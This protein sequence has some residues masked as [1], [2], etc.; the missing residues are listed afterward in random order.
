[1][2]SK[3]SQLALQEAQKMADEYN[4]SYITLEYLL[5]ALCSNKDTAEALMFCNVDIKKLQARLVEFIADNR[6]T[7][8]DKD[9]KAQPT[10]ALQRVLERAE[11]INNAIVPSN[12]TNP[13]KGN[14]IL[15]AILDEVD[16][17]AVYLLNSQG[18][19]VEDANDYL[20]YIYSKSVSHNSYY[21]PITKNKHMEANATLEHFAI[22]TEKSLEIFAVNLNEKVIAENL[23]PLVGRT[24]E[25]DRILQVLARQRKNNPL[26][27]GD[28]GVGKSAIVL[29]LAR[30]IEEGDA[31]KSMVECE[32]YSLDLGSLIAGTRYRGDLEKR[33]RTVIN[34]LK[35]KKNTILFID[36]IHTLIGAGAAG[37]D[38]VD[39]YR[40][41][42]PAIANGSVRCIGSTNYENYRS[43]FGKD[44]ALARYFQTVEVGKLSFDE[45]YRILDG[46]RTRLEDFHKVFYS[47]EAMK[48]AI[49]LSDRHIGDRHQPDKAIDIMDE[50][51]AFQSII[52]QNKFMNA[53]K[54]TVK[55]NHKDNNSYS[56]QEE[57]H[58]S[59]QV[60]PLINKEEIR[61]AIANMTGL[62]L[63]SLSEDA[64]LYLKNLEED[65]RQNIFG[66][67]QA[68]KHLV[69]AI[70][71]ARAGLNQPGRPLGCYMLAGPTGVGKTEVCLQLSK[72]VGINLI[73]F[74]MSEYSESH[75]VAKLIGA[76]PGYVG[77]DNDSQLAASVMKA[78]Y[79]LILFDEMEKAH[80][81]IFNILLQIMDYGTLTDNNGL[82][83][84]FRNTIVIITTNA[85]ADKMQQYSSGFT[86]HE[87]YDASQAITNTFNPEFRNRLDAII[88]FTGLTPF[89]M[90][91]V[92]VKFIDELQAQV[93]ENNII[94]E[95]DA[96]ARKWLAKHGYDKA[97]G[98]RPLL[99]LIK[100]KI[101]IPLADMI[102]FGG[103]EK[104]G[105]VIRISVD[106]KELTL[107]RE[108]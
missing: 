67:E 12:K 45:T 96:A 92:V 83:A 6:I 7:V 93:D 51:G 37:P 55:N 61:G 13:V 42:K 41:F 100:E 33:V 94:L 40:L 78:P 52:R 9:P 54:R 97:M 80:P 49:T 58:V 86:G 102:L 98:A 14:I 101:K 16:S 5:F 53:P 79:S 8:D 77:F 63:E 65:L 104:T 99:R 20:Q 64:R 30:A 73:R 56:D 84:D 68:I 17:D 31:P 89:I 22:N 29:G 70:K 60:I 69:S 85:G 48:E 18:V 47:E 32:I 24:E 81:N 76:P 90:E 10:V 91:Q 50:A 39:A 75:A 107:R 62:P 38:N 11:E 27:V 23:D 34:Q 59:N 25:I 21:Q 57:G 2:L 72:L 28:P 66:Q 74:D 15:R 87:L 44:N 71:M 106:K 35:K 1:M 108:L 3:D 88:Q 46:I 82:K 26:I 43:I 105:G 19:Y 95:L 4:N 36:D 103:M